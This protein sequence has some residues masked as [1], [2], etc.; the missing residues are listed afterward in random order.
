MCV[1]ERER[2][3]EREK[4]RE[5]E[6]ERERGIECEGESESGSAVGIPSDRH[7]FFRKVN[8]RLTEKINTNSHGAR[9]DHQII[10]MLKWIRVSKLSMKNSLPSSSCPRP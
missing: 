6:R 9:P 10:S 3:M 4:E 7:A 8:V 1:K 2:E 5:R